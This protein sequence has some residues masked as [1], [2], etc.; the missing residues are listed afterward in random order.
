MAW[1]PGFEYDIFISYAWVDN[2]TAEGDPE[3]KGW[4][5]LFQRYLYV[6]LSK[7][8]GR[9]NVLQIFRDTRKIQGNQL[10][11][12]TL[13]EAVQNSAVF[14]ALDSNGYAESEYCHQEIRSF[15]EKA[16]QDP[17]GLAAGD[18]YRIFHVLL[19]DLPSSEWP[20]QVGRTA[21]FP[22]HDS[23]EPNGSGDPAEHSSKRFRDCLRDLAEALHKTLKRLK[24][25]ATVEPHPGANKPAPFTIYL[26]ETSDTLRSIRKR[27]FSELGRVSD[28]KLV[29][30]IPP[31]FEAAE[32]DQ[33]V[34]QELRAADLSVHLLDAY[35][36]YPVAGL[37][38]ST[39]P[40]RQV[41]LALQHAKS[42]LIW[43]P[44]SMQYES[45]EEKWYE[46]FLRNLEDGP[47]TG[48]SYDFQRELPDAISRQI[49]AKLEETR[50]RA[51]D[52]PAALPTALLD[53][54]VKDQLLAFKLSNY[55]VDHGVQAYIN[56]Q[57][58]NPSSN[59]NEFT[60]RLKKV[61]ILIV[62]YGAVAEAWIRARLAVTLQIAIAEQCP[63]RACGVY[64]APPH[65]ASEHMP[66]LPLV[67]VEWMDHT[68]GFNASAI[69]HLL[70]RARGYGA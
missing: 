25:G 13:Q 28:L 55:L 23:D 46:T 42:Q 38:A 34:V 4:V 59:L 57:E 60:D 20:K 33:R 19:N 56:P 49:L 12:S 52:L 69:D 66:G 27:V 3:E 11:D 6:E 54:H 40:Q 16:R 22:F 70:G 7:K 45:I 10:F 64:V 18:H 51:L 41:E 39:Y 26:A 47:R 50:S 36:G 24:E 62:F 30:G 35:P 15:Y 44:R 8:L 21:G 9:M 37:E 68:S 5:S 31:P 43:V 29:T 14:L 53:T 17:V 67:S 65:K 63:L 61:A 32:H 2:Q 1:V 58:D 48:S